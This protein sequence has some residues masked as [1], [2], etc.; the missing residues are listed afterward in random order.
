[1]T[2]CKPHHMLFDMGQLRETDRFLYLGLGLRERVFDLSRR[3]TTGRI[4]VVDL[5]NPQWTSSR[6][7]GPAAA[8]GTP[9]AAR[10]PPQLANGTGHAAAPAG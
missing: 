5:Y 3:L 7:T 2:G 1:M 10:P 4:V 8:A 6:G 9:A